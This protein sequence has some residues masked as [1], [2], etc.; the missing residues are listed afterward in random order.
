MKLTEH[1]TLEE[2]IFSDYASRHGLDNSPTEGT[3]DNLVR[4]CELLEQVRTLIGKPIIVTSGYR[5]FLVNKGTGGQEL[6]QHRW[7]CAADI[8]VHGVTPREVCEKVIA[9]DI[10]YD[11]IILEWNSWTHISVPT[12]KLTTPRLSKLII[13]QEGVRVFQ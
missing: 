3:L 8:K 4:L 9:S 2:M 11:Q 5:S 6:S 13:D 12:D 7:G 10:E 1:F